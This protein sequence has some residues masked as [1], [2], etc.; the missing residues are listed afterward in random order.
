MSK[1]FVCAQLCPQ[2]VL[3]NNT[4]LSNNSCVCLFNCTQQRFKQIETQLNNQI[5]PMINSWLD[6][7]DLGCLWWVCYKESAFCESVFYQPVQSESL[8]LRN[9]FQQP[10]KTCN[11]PGFTRASLLVPLLWRESLRTTLVKNDYWWSI[12]TSC[13]CIAEFCWRRMWCCWIVPKRVR[14]A[15]YWPTNLLKERLLLGLKRLQ[16]QVLLCQ[17]RKK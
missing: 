14:M 3:Y 16:G 7:I 8:V 1:K 6:W 15:W 9:V 12:V 4:I 10:I 2:R 13:W 11:N 17:E 5:N